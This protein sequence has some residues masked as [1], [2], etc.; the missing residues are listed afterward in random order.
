MILQLRESSVSGFDGRV[1][2]MKCSNKWVACIIS[3]AMCRRD[4]EGDLP[5]PGL[6]VT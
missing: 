6:Q 2:S 4:Q 5:D 3:K 1:T